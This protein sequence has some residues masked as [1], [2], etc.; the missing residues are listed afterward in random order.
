MNDIICA[1]PKE[2]HEIADMIKHLKIVAVVNDETL[3][4]ASDN[5][6]LASKSKKQFEE[7][8]KKS[9]YYQHHYTALEKYYSLTKPIKDAIDA[10]SNAHEHEI[11]QWELA[12]RE[13]ETQKSIAQSEYS[14]VTTKFVPETR[15]TDTLLFITTLIEMG[16]SEWVKRIFTV[17]EKNLLEF[18]EIMELS[19]KKGF[20][21]S[22]T[23]IKPK[24]GVR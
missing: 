14:K 21:G 13:N 9:D 11:G 2:A 17:D 3:K 12:N 20:P 16:K 8:A 23:N 15:I 6:K 22:V 5:V 10:F 19:E 1:L 24:V 4:A 7:L 18:S